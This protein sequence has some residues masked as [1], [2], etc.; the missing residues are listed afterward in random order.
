MQDKQLLSP[1]KGMVSNQA[2]WDKFNKYI[3]SLIAQQHRIMEQ[4]DNIQ[5]ISRAQGG[6]YQLR[7]IKLLR[8]EVL[9]TS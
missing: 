2:Q 5:T 8:D 4:S 1:L 9:K 3:D 6:I 7:R